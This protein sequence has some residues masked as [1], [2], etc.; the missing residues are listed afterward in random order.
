M[1]ELS[2]ATEIL[3]TVQ[4]AARAHGAKSVTRVRLRVGALS[5]LNADS[6][7]FCLEAISDKTLLAGAAIEIV[8]TG[9]EL[10]CPRC[11]RFSAED[12]SPGTCP[13]CGGPAELSLAT[14]VCVEE[15]EAD[16]ED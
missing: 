9:P 11:G 1:H 14:D 3:A 5:G 15:I 13:V 16:G 12:V 6:L 8:E 2:F 4:Q 7:S 10:I